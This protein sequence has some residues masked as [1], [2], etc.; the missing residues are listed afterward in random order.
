M[1]HDINGFA[2]NMTVKE[3]QAK[4]GQPL[5]PS[6]GGQFDV[7]LGGKSYNFGFSA[8]GKLFRIDD[9][10]NLGNFVPDEAYG[11]SLM[12]KLTEKFG[13]PESSNLPGGAAFW[14]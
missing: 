5:K 9:E 12:R 14:Q 2:L 11:R 7:T 10:E 3:V 13:P 6:G 8:L 1:A 4:A